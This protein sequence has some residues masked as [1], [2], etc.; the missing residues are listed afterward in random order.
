MRN[1]AGLNKQ[2]ERF[3]KHPIFIHE[4][5]YRVVWG[6]D[7]DKTRLGYTKALTAAETLP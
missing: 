7:E 6:T 3:L 1:R 5:K 4:N 2:G